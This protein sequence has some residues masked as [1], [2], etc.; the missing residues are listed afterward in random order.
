MKTVKIPFVKN[1]SIS[2]NE[3]DKAY[4][5]VY[6]DLC[7]NHDHVMAMFNG[8]LHPDDIVPQRYKVDE[9]M[10]YIV[11]RGTGKQKE[12]EKN[13]EASQKMLLRLVKNRGNLVK[14]MEKE[15]S[16]INFIPPADDCKAY[17]GAVAKKNILGNVTNVY[18]VYQDFK[19]NIKYYDFPR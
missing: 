5:M 13:Y 16:F 17:M 19:G 9:M 14:R 8:T 7:K 10:E 6:E 2:Q 3:L 15:D 1:K 11:N 18:V 12:Y 4:K